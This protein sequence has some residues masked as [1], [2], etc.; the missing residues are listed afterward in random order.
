MNAGQSTEQEELGLLKILE[1][2]ACN[3]GLIDAK[4]DIIKE[5]SKRGM[6][7][8]V[9]GR[10]G[11]RQQLISSLPKG[12]VDAF[13]K[14]V[15]EISLTDESVSSI[16]QSIRNTHLSDS[17]KL[18]INMVMQYE[19]TVED[20]IK[21]H[22]CLT[23]E[24]VGKNLR[25]PV[26]NSTRLKKSLQ[27]MGVLLLHDNIKLVAPAFQFIQPDRVNAY[28]KEAKLK[29]ND[30]GLS[31]IDVCLFLLE[32]RDIQRFIP[33]FSAATSLSQAAAMGAKS[34]YLIN[35]RPL[36]LLINQDEETFVQA[37]DAWL[38][39]Q[40]HSLPRENAQQEKKA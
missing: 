15:N 21:S 12:S 29:A 28:I 3:N 33:D 34:D 27:D 13:N 20:F 14:V 25:L 22:H 16:M 26:S 10:P 39:P 18:R 31:T 1:V 38:D 24:E 5:M 37:L 6:I 2:T 9:G 17:D 19:S 8:L 32:K 11:F 36:T 30:R 23:L 35:E 4:R 40:S 7:T